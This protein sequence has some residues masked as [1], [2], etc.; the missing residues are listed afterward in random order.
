MARVWIELTFAFPAIY[1]FFLF[2]LNNNNNINV[3][4]EILLEVGIKYEID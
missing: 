1:I 4:T 3:I 2:R